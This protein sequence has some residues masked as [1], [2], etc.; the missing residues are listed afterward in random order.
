MKTIKMLTLPLCLVFAIT[1]AGQGQMTGKTDPNSPAQPVDS[2]EMIA[3]QRMV[4][5]ISVKDPNIGAKE[6][7]ND[8]LRHFGEV[9]Q[10]VVPILT[11][12]G[13]G[14]QMQGSYSYD[15]F[16]PTVYNKE[17]LQGSPF[18]LSAYVPGLVI[19]EQN[20]VIDKPDYLY[21]YDKMSGNCLL[22][23]NKEKPIAVNKS[24]VRF[25]CLRI[26]NG[27]YIFE[28]VSQINPNEFFQILYKGPKYSFY[29]LYKSKF[30]SA[31]QKTNG[32]I[33]EGNNYDE[34]QDII[35]YYLLDQSKGEA[36]IFELTKKSIR[37]TLISESGAVEQYIKDHKGDD[38]DE[39]YTVHLLEKINQ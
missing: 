15:N 20:T 13:S 34:Y 25:F 32:Y 21:N 23:R 18:L 38:V 31:G 37:K 14:S 33:S 24:Q 26:A 6:G 7:L 1:A 36:Q 27:G 10:L 17:A 19:N 16:L 22:Q 11:Y 29:K 8:S 4:Q 30:V 3:F 28:R 12:V 9:H 39:S 2:T 35:T 5:F